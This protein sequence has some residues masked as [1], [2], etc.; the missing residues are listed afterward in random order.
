MNQD[1][2]KLKSSH[3]FI[4][5]SD[6][7]AVKQRAEQLKA[8]LAPEDSLN[9]DVVDGQADNVEQAQQKVK[10]CLDAILTLPFLGGRK[11]VY[12]KNCTFLGDSPAGR[13]EEVVAGLEKIVEQLQKQSPAD[14]QVLWSGA[15]VDKRRS[16]FKKLEK[17]AVCEIHDQMELRGARAEEAWAGQVEGM[18]RAKGLNP[19]PGVAELLV[20]MLGADARAMHGEIEKIALFVH[21]RTE[22]EEK[23]VRGIAAAMRGVMVWD[24]CDAVTEGRSNESLHL[25][26]QLLHQGESDVGLLIQ[27]S[28]HLRLA[29]LGAYLSEAGLMS[30]RGKGWGAEAQLSPQAHD[31]LPKTKKGEQ[32]N[33]KRLSRITQQASRR[34]ARAWFEVLEILYQTSFALVSTGVDRAKTLESAILRICAI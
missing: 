7:F 12:F 4:A 18:L 3:L 32:V 21:P 11:L 25:L 26:R 14:V 24:L 30:I 17:A 33:L 22:V 23:D 27:L 29:A 20:E 5:G 31:L 34:K 15:N 1:P 8:A 13:N 2:G 6:D 16:W 10:L 9:L 28:G 19:A